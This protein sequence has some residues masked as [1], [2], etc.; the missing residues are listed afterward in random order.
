MSDWIDFTGKIALVTG[1]SRGIGAGMVEAFNRFGARC[2][3]NYVGD[4]QGRNEADAQ[5][6]AAGL[7]DPVVIECDVS[8]PASIAAMF[9]RVQREL[10]RLDILINNAGIIRDQTIKKISAED[11]NTVLNVN[12]S[13]TFHCIQHASPM[14]RPGGRVVNL[15]SVAG[16]LGLFGQAGYA[17]SKAAIM[18][19]TR[20]AARELA[21]QRVTV[22]AI[23][24][25][26][27]DTD[28]TRSMPE[29][30]AKKFLDQL[31]AGRIGKIDDVVDAALFLCSPH[32]DY[33]TGQVLH[34]NGGFHMAG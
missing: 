12:L 7:K 18:A 28:M 3:V 8:N 33:I 34:V 32:A 1:S 23:A 14:L 25:G 27:I 13:G 4:P 22:N 9:D 31:P 30:V 16:S 6:V 15:A 29:E 21:R 20:V 5:R 10:G 24:P 17:S 19:L 2:V 26:F 11:W